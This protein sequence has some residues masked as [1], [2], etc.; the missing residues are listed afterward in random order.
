MA[1]CLWLGRAGDPTQEKGEQR[2]SMQWAGCWY[3]T[4]CWGNGAGCLYQHGEETQGG[5]RETHQRKGGRGTEGSKWEAHQGKGGKG[6]GMP[7][8]RLAQRPVVVVCGSE[9]TPRVWHTPNFC[10][11][12]VGTTTGAST[13][14]GHFFSP[15]GGNPRG[16]SCRQP[17]S[18]QREEGRERREGR[19][20]AHRRKLLEAI[21]GSKPV[22]NSS[23]WQKG[24]P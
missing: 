4:A 17:R 7:G 6:R 23:A 21:D 14:K 18:W 10:T 12:S 19:S 2:S 20:V 3:G 13:S 9:S 24:Q 8:V 16:R 5:R 1:A 11:P 15:L 22:A